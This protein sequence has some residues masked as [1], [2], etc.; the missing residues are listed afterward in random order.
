MVPLWDT[1]FT[2]D[3]KWQPNIEAKLKKN[4]FDLFH[5]IRSC[6]NHVY[7]HLFDVVFIHLPLIDLFMVFEDKL[8]FS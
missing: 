7:H 3:I 2:L 1:E 6:T 5:A 8:A 4:N